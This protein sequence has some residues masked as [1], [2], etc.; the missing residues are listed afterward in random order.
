MEAP[1]RIIEK[2]ANIAI[3]VAVVV[4]LTVVIR[5][6]YLRRSPAPDKAPSELIGTTISLPGVNFTS[7]HASLILGISTQCHFCNE[8][9]PFYKQIADQLRGRVAVIAVMPQTEAEGGSYLEGA[10]ATGVQVVSAKLSS[11]GVYATPTVVLVDNSGKVKSAWVGKLDDAAQQK[12]LAAALSQS[13][14][15]LSAN[16]TER[17][18]Q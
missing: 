11:I 6:G 10:G 14:T 8:S 1:V 3:I 13:A 12:V 18:G 7:R 16:G 9:L 2:F 17:N 5:G 4:F 15:A